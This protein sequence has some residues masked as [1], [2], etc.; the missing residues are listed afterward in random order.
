[1]LRPDV[2][3]LFK[4]KIVSIR[5][6]NFDLQFGKQLTILRVSYGCFYSELQVNNGFLKKKKKRPCKQ[7]ALQHSCIGLLHFPPSPYLNIAGR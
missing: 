2:H 4:K 7:L 5:S 6:R 3:F 1:M